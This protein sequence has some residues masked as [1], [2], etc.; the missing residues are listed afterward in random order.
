MSAGPLRTCRTAPPRAALDRTAAPMSTRVT[1]RPTRHDVC[2]G[3]RATAVLRDPWLGPALGAP[4]RRPDDH[5]PELGAAAA[6]P[7]R[8]QACDRRGAPGPRAHGR[9]GPSDDDRGAGR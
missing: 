4:A 1:Y 2:T 5:R 3:E 9:H 7:R 8:Q 6:A